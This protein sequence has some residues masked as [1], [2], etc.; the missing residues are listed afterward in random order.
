M[1]FERERLALLLAVLVTVYDQ[2]GREELHI[3]LV[4][5]NPQ[6]QYQNLGFQAVIEASPR[7]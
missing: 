7:G 5:S 4:S 6:Q 3:T 2:I 1:I